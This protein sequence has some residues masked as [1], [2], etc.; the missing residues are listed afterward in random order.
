[1]SEVFTKLDS[2]TLQYFIDI[3]KE[4]NGITELEPQEM[5][6]IRQRG[7]YVDTPDGKYQ[8]SH[9]IRK[10]LPSA[11]VTLKSGTTFFGSQ[12]H[13]VKTEN[14]GFVFSKDINENDLIKDNSGLT[15]VESVVLNDEIRDFYDISVD[16]PSASYFT[17]DGVCHHNTGKTQITE[18]TLA[19]LGRTDGNGYFKN[20][21]AATAKGI[22][23]VLYKYR[24]EVVFFDEADGALKDQDARNMFKSATDT[25]KV[26]KVSWGSGGK[27]MVDP[28]KMTDEDEMEGKLPTWFE[29]TGRIIFISNLSLDKLDPDKALR[30]RALIIDINP[31]DAEVIDQMETILMK[32]KLEDGLV[33]DEA[34]R[35]EV[36]EV[37]RGSKNKEDV[38]LRKLVRGLNIRAASG[39]DPS[40]KM[41]IA[42]Y[43]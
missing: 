18:D 23:K 39:S 17:K 6:P 19:E 40:W 15:S 35:R 10:Q 26:R 1:M 4:E 5:Y 28:D 42:R 41:I 31:T 8:V 12:N 20:V 2:N 30:T 24:N 7:I 13:L 9:V 32:I 37:I 36:L 27:D 33:L 29:F 43:A 16:A 3:V 22:Y 38:S 34:G 11:T 14:R 21:G 25:K